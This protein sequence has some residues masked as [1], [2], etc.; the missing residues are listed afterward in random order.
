M[1]FIA[2]QGCSHFTFSLGFS[3]AHLASTASVLVAAALVRCLGNHLRDDEAGAV[4][5]DGDEGEVGGGDVAKALGANVFDH[6]ADADF[7]GGAEG[8]VDRGL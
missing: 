4:P 3:R 5:F 2:A 1:P 6:H 7:H 8:A